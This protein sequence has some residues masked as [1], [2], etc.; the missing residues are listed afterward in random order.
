MSRMAEF[1]WQCLNHPLEVKSI[2]WRNRSLYGHKRPFCLNP[3]RWSTLTTYL[4]SSLQDIPQLPRSG[5]LH[6]LLQLLVEELH[7][8]LPG[9]AF[10][11][12]Q[13]LPLQPL[14]LKDG[15]KVHLQRHRG[16]WQGGKKHRKWHR[17][18]DAFRLDEMVRD[19]G[20]S[21]MWPAETK[22]SQ[23][24]A[25]PSPWWSTA[26]FSRNRSKRAKSEV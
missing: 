9:Q 8:L 17:C 23:C 7:N 18:A 12:K 11:G 16:S 6:T 22:A 24:P 13:L 1:L 4:L 26:W 14:G 10:L 2:C 21:K 25:N 3:S 5:L 15:T 20:S 19:G